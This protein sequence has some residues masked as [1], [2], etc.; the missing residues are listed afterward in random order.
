M[1][2]EG[3][4]K[5]KNDNYYIDNLYLNT[6]VIVPLLFRARCMFAYTH[7][8]IKESNEHQYDLLLDVLTDFVLNTWGFFYF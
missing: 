6:E 1:A 3:T 2:S 7:G 5:L 8:C 4:V